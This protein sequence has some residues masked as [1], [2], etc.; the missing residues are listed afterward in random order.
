MY[1]SDLLKKFTQL[2]KRNFSVIIINELSKLNLSKFHK[3]MSKTSQ[4]EKD[5]QSVMRHC[6]CTIISYWS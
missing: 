5:E 4:F 6:K 3:K 1:I 2:R